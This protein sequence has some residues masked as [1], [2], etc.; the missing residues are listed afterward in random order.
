MDRYIRKD[1]M[2]DITEYYKIMYDMRKFEDGYTS[3][4]PGCDYGTSVSAAKVLESEYCRIIRN[5]SCNNSC[6]DVIYVL[7]SVEHQPCNHIL[8]RLHTDDIK[9][10][11]KYGDMYLAKKDAFECELTG[12]IYNSYVFNKTKKRG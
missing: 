6:N 12:S 5:D 1:T 8:N 9:E 11:M 3:T 7:E 10:L 4:L 2:H